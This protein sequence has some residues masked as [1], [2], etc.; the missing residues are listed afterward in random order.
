[1][2]TRLHR[3]FYTSLL[4]FC[5]QPA[6]AEIPPIE[7]EALLALYNNTSG[8]QWHNNSGWQAATA[9]TCSWYGVSCDVN[10]SFV[11]ELQLD[12]N[13]LKGPLPESLVNLSQLSRISINYNGVYSDSQSVNDFVQGNSE[14]NYQNSQTLDASG[15]RFDMVSNNSL[16]LSWDMASYLDNDGGYRI[17]LA[18]QIDSESGSVTTEFVKQGEDIVGKANTTTTLTELQACR[19]YF[20]KIISYTD[21]HSANSHAIES[22]G[23]NAQ[24]MGTITGFDKSCKIIGSPYNDTFSIDQ[25]ISDAPIAIIEVAA[26]GERNYQL[27]GSQVSN[28]D[29]GAGDDSLTILGEQDNT[30]IVTGNN[31]GD[32]NGNFFSSI[33]SL[34]GGSGLDTFNVTDGFSGS[35]DGGAGDDSLTILGEQDN[36]WTVTGNNSGD[37]NG[38][39]FS[40]IESLI[41]GSG[42]DTFN[43]TGDILG[44]IDGGV[45]VGV[46]TI[47]IDSSELASNWDILSSCDSTN[48]VTLSS[49]DYTA[50]SNNCTT[51]A[52]IIS[53]G[54]GGIL[55]SGTLNPELVSLVGEI[56]PLSQEDILQLDG[57]EIPTDDGNTCT[58]SQGRCIAEDGSV[59]VLS[60]DGSKLVKENAASGSLGFLSLFLCLI[61]AGFRFKKRAI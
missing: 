20:V 21:A 23:L 13:N 42:A 47:S 12:A 50:V 48:N 53:A 5:L 46:D 7:R 38:N 36:T 54:E 52:G 22:D 4:S 34:I 25:N 55:L 57:L 45:G 37:V 43:I 49:T 15:A 3:I 10:Q 29:G 11:T 14:L 56:T 1:L 9:D 60:D 24:V 26:S 35:I 51:S 30:W 31:S 32:V 16:Q 6:F 33:E 44:S 19:Q 39:L 58:F 8:S 2:N 61:C 27:S 41:G 59:Y 18:E 40:S 17:Y 28:I